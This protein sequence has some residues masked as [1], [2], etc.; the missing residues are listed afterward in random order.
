MSDPTGGYGNTGGPKKDRG[1]QRHQMSEDDSL[2]VEAYGARGAALRKTVATA[3]EAIETPG[4][5]TKA[6][7]AVK[8]AMGM[9]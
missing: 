5:L 2:A 3:S 6:V 1:H 7:R 8:H 4:P 9:D